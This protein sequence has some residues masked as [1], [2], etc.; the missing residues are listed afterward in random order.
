MKSVLGN[1][2][3]TILGINEEIF[4]DS[5]K[6][7]S[8]LYHQ[9]FVF[10]QLIQFL[11]VFPGAAVFK[12]IHK[13]TIEPGAFTGSGYFKRT[14]DGG[15]TLAHSCE[16]VMARLGLWPGLKAT[17]VVADFHCDIRSAVLQLDEEVLVKI[18]TEPRNALVRQYQRFFEMEGATLEFSQE[19]LTAVATKAIAL[20]TGARA[21]RSVMEGLMLEL[22]YELPESKIAGA[23]YI[24]TKENVDVGRKLRLADILVE[25]KESA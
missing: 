21:L 20:D 12:V 25:K 17:A 7:K 15:S 13:Q 10:I 9:W 5:H 19:A 3:D 23:R 16:A 8:S 24:V 6:R 2:L 4:E 22:M 14:A 18:L 1:A 11:F